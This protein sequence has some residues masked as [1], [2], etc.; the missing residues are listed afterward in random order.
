MFEKIKDFVYE[1]ST[2]VIVVGVLFAASAALIVFS[3]EEPAQSP[4]QEVQVK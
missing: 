1:Y 2:A 3:G 4:A